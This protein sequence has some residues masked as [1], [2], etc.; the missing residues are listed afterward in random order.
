MAKLYDATDG[1]LIGT[2]TEGQLQFLIDQLVEE[3]MEDQD[4]YV[5]RTT[6]IWFEEHGAE[7]ELQAILTKALGERE[8]MDIRWAKD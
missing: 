2:I 7:P 3:D 1:T 8:G 4:Y 6:L 5:D